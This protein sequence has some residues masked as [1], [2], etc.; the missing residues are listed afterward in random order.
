MPRKILSPEQIAEIPARCP[1]YGDASRLARQWGVNVN[2]IGYHLRGGK[3][4]VAAQAMRA[5][6]RKAARLAA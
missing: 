4:Y 3:A 2:T 6:R 5:E 1:R